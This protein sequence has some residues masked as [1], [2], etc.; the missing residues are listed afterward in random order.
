ML[1]V[2]QFLCEDEVS[3]VIKMLQRKTNPNGYNI[4]QALTPHSEK[5]ESERLKRNSPI[6]TQEYLQG[7]YLGREII[8]CDTIE[9][10]VKNHGQEDHKHYLTRF[11]ARNSR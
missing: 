4:I 5:E 9:S 10:A 3:R 6:I 8:H 1:N 2:L 7:F 11:I